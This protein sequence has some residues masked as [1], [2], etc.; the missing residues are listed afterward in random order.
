ME[1]VGGMLFMSAL[2]LGLGIGGFLLEHSRLFNKIVDRLLS[3]M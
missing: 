1:I 3:L 2:F